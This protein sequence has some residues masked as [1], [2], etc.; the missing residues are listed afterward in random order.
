MT[1]AAAPTRKAAA[2]LNTAKARFNA[3][4]ADATDAAGIAMQAG[5]T[6]A[7]HGGFA[8][9]KDAYDAA[10]NATAVA[11]T[12]LDAGQR[13]INAATLCGSDA[14]GP[15]TYA[16]WQAARMLTESE[17]VRNAAYQALLNAELA[18]HRANR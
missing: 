2:V 13:Y 5:K 11:Q 4:L 14:I 1:T 9:A 12:A 8:F 3:A 7:L 17:T 15:A 10:V 18:E 16:V 6:A